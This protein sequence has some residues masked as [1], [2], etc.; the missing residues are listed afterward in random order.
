MDYT[1][2][3]GDPGP[4][5]WVPPPDSPL[6]TE[7]LAWLSNYPWDWFLTVTFRDMVPMRRQ[8]SVL[9]AVGETLRH[10]HIVKRL[11]L[12]SE[13]TKAQ[14]LHLHGL[15]ASSAEDFVKPYQKLDIRRVLLERFGRN[16][17]EVPRGFAD[18]SRYVTKYCLK[19]GG[20][21]EVW[22]SGD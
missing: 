18:V 6:A 12:I 5:A 17:V 21:Y 7:W 1:K 2:P 3:I 16:K 22:D 14:A 13:A 11:F 4:K 10:S 8:E 19:D 15:Y 20:Y 9:H